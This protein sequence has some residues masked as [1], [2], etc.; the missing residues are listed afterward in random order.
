VKKEEVDR[1]EREV[2]DILLALAS[3][4]P[5]AIKRLHSDTFKICSNYRRTS[6]MER[7]RRKHADATV[8]GKKL[9]AIARHA[10]KIAD[11]LR[12]LPPN[13]SKAITIDLDAFI[14]QAQILEAAVGVAK[15]AF[16][17]SARKG[18]RRWTSQDIDRTARDIFTAYTGRKAGRIDKS[19]GKQSTYEA[20]LQALFT[21]LAIT[22]QPSEVI[23]RRSKANKQS[24]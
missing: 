15:G 7:E 9:D 19:F 6:Y 20:F 12:S 13:L 1:I 4:N 18:S 16:L 2:R 17:P 23:R 3:N 5:A 21:A 11:S 8:G 14:E 22:D 24:K 10:S